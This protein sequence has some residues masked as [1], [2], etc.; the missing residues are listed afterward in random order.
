MKRL[1]V[2]GLVGIET[3]VSEEKVESS[4]T[5]R[6]FVVKTFEGHVGVLG[7]RGGSAPKGTPPP[8]QRMGIPH[9][10]K[11]M[12]PRGRPVYDW[13][14]GGEKTSYV[15][16]GTARLNKN[17]MD[18]LYN[19]ISEN[20]ESNPG[21]EGLEVAVPEDQRDT[22]VW[23]TQKDMIEQ[24]FDGYKLN[25]TPFGQFYDWFASD[26]R[27]AND[28]AILSNKAMDITTAMIEGGFSPRNYHIW[29]KNNAP[30][31][32][33]TYNDIRVSDIYKDDGRNVAVIQISAPYS[34]KKFSVYTDE[35]GY[36]TP[37]FETDSWQDILSQ[38]RT[39]NMFKR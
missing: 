37:A 14:S 26:S 18:R 11:V 1:F 33:G 5:K 13:K 35:D 31:S 7:H 20:W 21:R 36:E 39:G 10:F 22:G 2:D 9:N 25:E 12:G 29:F 27:I 16:G 3:P 8:I 23:G 28:A 4:P 34:E 24:Y 6:T 38:F 17:K 19:L 32:G 15:P 30:M